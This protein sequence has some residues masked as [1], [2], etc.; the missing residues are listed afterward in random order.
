MTARGLG[1]HADVL[2][3]APTEEAGI[4]AAR[5]ILARPRLPTAVLTHNDQMALG[6]LLTLRER[7]VGVPGRISVIGYDDTRLASLSTIRLTSVSQDAEQLAGAAITRAI[8]RTE[9]P[10]GAAAEYVTAPRLVLR[11]TTGPPRPHP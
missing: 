4:D 6:L 8:A 7:G 2:A 10:G 9:E 3:A 11:N 5:R 1:E